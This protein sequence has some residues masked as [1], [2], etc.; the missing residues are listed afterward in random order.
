MILGRPTNLWLGVVTALTGAVTVTA[1]ALGL[2]PTIV[3]TVA[4]AFGGVLGA[5]I[6]LVAGQPPTVAAGG[7]IAVQTPAGEPNATATV[8]VAPSGEVTV[9]PTS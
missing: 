1:V 4:G 2:D 3:A 8:N 5:I 9:Q 6:A 7:A